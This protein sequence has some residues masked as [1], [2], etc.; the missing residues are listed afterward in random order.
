MFGFS[1]AVGGLS[2][3]KS[4]MELSAPIALGTVTSITKEKGE[5]SGPTLAALTDSP[6][7]ATTAAV[8][9]IC[10]DDVMHQELMTTASAGPCLAERGT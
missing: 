5:E 7:S 8:T 6:S 2:Y 1:V 10:G 4:V 9:S 3:Q